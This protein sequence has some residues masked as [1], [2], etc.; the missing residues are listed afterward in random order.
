MKTMNTFLLLLLA[1]SAVLATCASAQT[2]VA[3]RA[4]L[5]KV[6]SRSSFGSVIAREEAVAAARSGSPGVT[7][8]SRTG[9]ASTDRL[10]DVDGYDDGEGNECFI[11][12][13]DDDFF[14]GTWRPRASPSRGCEKARSI[15]IRRTHPPRS[16]TTRRTPGTRATAGSG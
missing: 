11:E 5:L 7:V 15:L 13:D 4:A 6:A 8:A 2:G 9:F 10:F 1:V 3:S 14:P 12:D 16:Q